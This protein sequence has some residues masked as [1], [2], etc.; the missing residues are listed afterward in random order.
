MDK[1]TADTM[2]ASP[3]VVLALATIVLAW[4]TYQLFQHTKVLAELTKRLLTIE[5]QRDRREQAE[6]RRADLTKCVAVARTIWRA[7]LDPLSWNSVEQ[8][9]HLKEV[10]PAVEELLALSRYIGEAET[11]STLKALRGFLDVIARL[12]P[13]QQQAEAGELN[14]PAM[15]QKLQ[16]NLKPQIDTWRKELDQQS[17]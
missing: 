15:M 1:P 6:H 7:N 5:E 4:C 8:Q 13:P 16:N 14:L 12:E 17:A 9:G 3:T 11:I 2:L 10:I